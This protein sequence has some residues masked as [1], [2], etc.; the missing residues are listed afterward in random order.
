[1]AGTSEKNHYIVI[2]CGGTGPRLWPLSRASNPKQFLHLF[3]PKSLLEQTI[4]RALKI[5][6]KENIYI[7]SNQIYLEKIKEITKNLISIKNIISEPLKKNTALA[8]VYAS[9]LI[10]SRNPDAVISSMP[11]DHYIKNI[12]KFKN[13]LTKAKKLAKKY[14]SVITFGIKPLRPDTSYGYIVPKEK[15]G[16]FQKVSKFIEKPEVSTAKKLI[17]QGAYWNS[18]I[19]TFSLSTLESELKLLD[20][21]YYQAFVD[22]LNN[23]DNPKKITDVYLNSQELAF[24]RVISERSNDMM[25]IPLSADWNDVGEWETIFHTLPKDK[26]NI[27]T[28]GTQNKFSQVNSKNCLIK[29]AK[30]KIIGLVGVENLAII[31]TEDALLICNMDNNGSYQ[32]RDLIT[33]IVKD[34]KLEDYFLKLPKSD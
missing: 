33:Q 23:I 8:I 7:I 22:L 19:Y 6:S 14:K 1:M 5:T 25:N 9:A 34:K 18:G 10:K 26:N 30:N 3:E 24:D 31:D 16:N 13:D 11:S 12:N 15:D 21:D 4:N 2:L 28:L 20:Q 27:A 17:N 29:T 32:V